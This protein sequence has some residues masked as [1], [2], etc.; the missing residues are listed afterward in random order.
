MN[1]LCITDAVRQFGVTSKTLRYYER[2]GLL[3]AKRADNNNYRYYDDAEVERMKQIM[4]LRKMQISIKEIIRIYEN[5]D[6]STVV[7]VFVNRI[8]VINDE[9]GALSEL[10]RITN[11]FLQVMLQNG[12][13]KISTLPILYEQMEKQ[14]ETLE[15]RK[16]IN[17]ME[18]SELSDKLVKPVEPSILP[19]PSMR[20][21]SSVRKDGITDPDGFWRWV[22][23]K[24]IPQGEPGRHER[25]EFQTEAGDVFILQV[26]DDFVNDSVYSDYIFGG[27]L[28]AVVNVYLDEDIA[29]RFRTLIKDF[30]SNKYYQIDYRS[31]G[32]LRHGAM[33]E[34]LISPDD[35]RELVALLIPVK[36][37]MADP[38][39]FD[40]PEEVHGIT[41]AEIEAAN[42]TLW[43]ANVELAK[44]T[45]THMNNS[46]FHINEDGEAEY[47][48]WIIRAVLNTNVLV[49]LP[50]RVDIEFRLSGEGRTGI[51][52]YHSEDTGYLTGHIGKR[53]FGV[54]M[55][56]DN[57]QMIQAIHF[58]QPIFGDGYYFPGRGAIKKDD[59]N[60]LTWIVGEKHLAVIINGEIRYCGENFPYMS[61][62]LS[63][64][65]ACPIVIGAHGNDKI[66]F[67]SIHFSQLTETKKNKLKGELTMITKQ[68]NNIIPVIHRLVTDEYGEN[69]WFNGCAKYV[70]E[71]LGE[72]DYDYWFFAG[73]TGDLF[74]QHYTYTKSSRDALSS[75]RMDENPKQ[76]V[77]DTFA[78]C[79]YAATY[80]TNQELCEN[81]EMY[82]NTLMAYI[83][84]GIP[85]II[86][87]NSI[88][89]VYVGYEEYGKILLYIT[90]NNNKPE[91]I[92]VD[93][94]TKGQGGWIF[95]GEKKE[96]R[97]L[98]HIYRD[99]I[100][101][102]P[103]HLNVKEDTYC[104]GVGAFRAW[105]SDI[106]NGKFDGMKTEEFSA[107]PYYTNYVCVLA[108]NGSCCYGFFDKA[109]KLNPDYAWLDK[110]KELYRRTGQMWNN[111]NGNDLEALGGGFNVT[112]EVLQDK[113]KRARIAAV[114]RK[115]GD[116]IEE[117][118][119]ILK[120]NLSSY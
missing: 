80:V 120:S 109:Q 41:V 23:E 39:L 22:Q 111:D 87:G 46:Y 19:L 43:E 72:S 78:K 54:N 98:A 35:Q 58:H 59:L 44:L 24:G 85:V 89:G 40:Q 12:V 53:G 34:D 66:Y 75:Y 92:T 97:P 65:E 52:F 20:V 94:A 81:T 3:D 108:T 13:T 101:A 99:A 88:V 55:G 74:T 76:F 104:F 61:L 2:V 37:R 67:R 73:L 102:I 4:I 45:Q 96:S 100:A 118:V 30:D 70:M 86:W 63:R 77:K 10:K 60:R 6:M 117:I 47:I 57:E 103:K 84:K 51:V 11:E 107:W 28:F 9:I 17:Y 105:A 26:S 113:E 110:V 1:G 50:F 48:G 93:D 33:L 32:S 21:L 119:Q 82:L 49:K 68:S 7:E 69:Y 91:R 36:K 71:C 16:T 25:F 106:E 62:D 64:E 8:N 15:K 42:P 5:E 114:I 95:V 56:N 83:D 115:C 90:G 116:C 112:L 79:G 18:L 27:G 14:L 29:G 31:D 38:G